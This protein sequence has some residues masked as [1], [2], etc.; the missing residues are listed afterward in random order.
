[1]SAA[2]LGN[3]SQ[4][5]P[6]ST[7][8]AR[9]KDFTSK[10]HD[11][12]ANPERHSTTLLVRRK[13]PE[14]I[15]SMTPVINN[16]H[17]QHQSFRY[18]LM[19]ESQEIIVPEVA[20]TSLLPL[21]WPSPANFTQLLLV[22]AMVRSG[23]KVTHSWLWMLGDCLKFRNNPWFKVMVSNGISWPTLSI[24]SAEMGLADRFLPALAEQGEINAIHI[25]LLLLVLLLCYI[26]YFYTT[27]IKSH[28]I[29][30]L[31]QYRFG[32]ALPHQMPLPASL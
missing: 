32:P 7:L 5:T 25:G 19:K 27:A 1:M 23:R 6:A 4:E 14:P 10:L 16:I 17:T 2:L 11:L 30:E 13:T 20:I 15:S 8:G 24:T 31:I 3:P 29:P 18:T 22:K 21:R 26:C 9:K 12:P 28:A